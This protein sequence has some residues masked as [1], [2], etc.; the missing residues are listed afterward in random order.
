MAAKGIVGAAF[1]ISDNA[2]AGI[3]Y[4]YF[5]TDTGTAVTD[6]VTAHAIQASVKF[7]F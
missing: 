6:D 4:Q 2:S 3:E 5:W 1:A 7:N